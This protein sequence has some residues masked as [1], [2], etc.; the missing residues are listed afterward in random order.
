[1]Q[2][3]IDQFRINIRYVR[4]MGALHKAL[5][6]QTTNALDL[7]DIL[8]AE[9]VMAVSALDKYIH[10]VVRDGMLEAYIG[11]RSK[12]KKFMQFSITLGS[13]QAGISTPTNV[14]WLENEIRNRHSWLSFQRAD[15][16]ADA[17]HLFSDIDLWAEVAKCIGK[18]AEDIRIQQNLIIDRRNCIAHEADIDP[19]YAS[20]RWTI[21]DAMVDEAI[22]F[23]ERVAE[24]IYVVCK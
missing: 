21:N 24:A 19:S 10:D 6:A 20:S 4:N 22:D 23:V 16:I 11:K 13:V 17:I 18:N 12:T 5:N 2:A 14:D 15:K 7:S 1:M 8:R 3:A 9:L